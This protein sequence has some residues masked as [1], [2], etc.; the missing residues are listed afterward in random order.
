MWYPP[1]L[2]PIMKEVR[3]HFFRTLKAYLEVAQ[4]L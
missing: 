3:G 4:H 2:L 1:I